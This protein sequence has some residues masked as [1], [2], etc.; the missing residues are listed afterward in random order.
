MPIIDCQSHLFPAAYADFLASHP[1][2]GL[3]TSGGNGLYTVD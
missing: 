3:S 1:T 2:A